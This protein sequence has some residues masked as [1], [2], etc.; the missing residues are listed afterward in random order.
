VARGREDKICEEAIMPREHYDD[1]KE[2]VL[3]A[4]CE[5][6]GKKRGWRMSG[7]KWKMLLVAGIGL[8]RVCEECYQKG[9]WMAIRPRPMG[10]KRED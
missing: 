1:D 10:V 4:V 2:V 9:G 5:T 7:A 6:C 8:P 3:H